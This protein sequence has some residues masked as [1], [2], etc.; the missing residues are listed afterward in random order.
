MSALIPNLSKSEV[1][2]Y[3]SLISPR[4]FQLIYFNISFNFML[5]TSSMVLFSLRIFLIYLKM[6]SSICLEVLW[7]CVKLWMHC[8][9]CCYIK[10]ERISLNISSEALCRCSFLVDLCQSSRIKLSFSPYLQSFDMNSVLDRTPFCNSQR[11]RGRR[12]CFI[13][14]YIDSPSILLL[15]IP[16]F[17]NWKM[18]FS[19]RWAWQVNFGRTFV[20]LK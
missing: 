5:R 20:L 7:D 4:S 16:S 12:S 8:R 6:I 17:I 15:I 3:D 10:R 1:N 11:H 18:Y 14:V 13:W 19:S 9:I 2:K